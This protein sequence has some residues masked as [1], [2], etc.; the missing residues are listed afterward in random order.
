VLRE[1]WDPSKSPAANLASMGLLA[2][3]NQLESNNVNFPAPE[4]EESVVELFD[5]PD[6]DA[7]TRRSKFPLDEEE[8][9]YIAKCMA[10][11]G[12]QYTKMFRDIK[13]NKMQHTEVQLR[14]MGARFLLL[15]PTQR[16]VEVPAKVQ[17]LLPASSTDDYE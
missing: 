17:L 14:K 11:H 3:P 13:I 15:S 7:P 12:D 8:E 5:V 2:R 16:R 10:K 6:S 4:K 9:K 1:H